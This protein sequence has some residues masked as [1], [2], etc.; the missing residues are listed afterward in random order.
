MNSGKKLLFDKYI[1][2][3]PAVQ[4]KSLSSFG[5]C[6][7]IPA[8]DEL[9]QLPAVLK[10]IFE[11]EKSS[12][13]AVLVVVNHPVGKDD[14]S[15]LETCDFLQKHPEYSKRLFFIYAPEISGGVG[16]ARKKGMDAYILSRGSD[17]AE[18]SIIFSLDADTLVDKNYFCRV[19][20]AFAA[21]TALSAVMIP[22]LHRCENSENETAI[23][24]YEYYLA[25]YVSG[26]AA[27]GSPYAVQTVGSAFA[28]RASSYIRCGGMKVKKAGED[29]Y[30]IC[31]LIKTGTV[32]TLETPPLVYPSGRIS[33]R[34]PFGTGTAV[35][36]LAAGESLNW[37]SDESFVLLGKVL[38]LTAGAENLSDAKKFLDALPV[39]CREFFE[40]EKFPEIWPKVLH[41]TPGAAAARKKAFDRWFDG[42]KTLRFL[43]F[44]NS[45]RGSQTI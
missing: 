25:R 14:E 20:E 30:F 5:G 24:D 43:H 6:V 13:V 34:T 35:A 4:I 9:S 29:F 42:L 28:C 31:E 44:V 17:A 26:L 10:S 39:G 41:N 11:A 7:V 37:I 40:A 8:W 22:Y 21:D 33:G 27:A 15:S 32:A 36:K 16:E 3:N 23:R 19:T 38:S 45:M 18:Q 2:R 1:R 12:G